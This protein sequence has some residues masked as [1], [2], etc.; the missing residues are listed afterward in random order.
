VLS[1]SRYIRLRTVLKRLEGTSEINEWLS[2]PA[3]LAIGGLNVGPNSRILYTKEVIEVPELDFHELL[4][5]HLGKI[6]ILKYILST[7]IIVFFFLAPKRISKGKRRKKKIRNLSQGSNS[8]TSDSM[9]VESDESER[10]MKFN[11][12]SLNNKACTIMIGRLI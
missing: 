1:Y 5:N 6:Y 3:I 8:T 4:C 11:Y 7:L 10:V 9:S 12:L 2:N